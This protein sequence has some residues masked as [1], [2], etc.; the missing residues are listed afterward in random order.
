MIAVILSLMLAGQGIPLSGPQTGTVTGILK[1]SLGRP[2]PGVRVTALTKPDSV[3]DLASVSAMSGIAQTDA[4]GKF[5]LE[6][7]PPGGYFIAAGRLDVQTFYPGTPDVVDAKE[8][9][10]IAGATVSGVD[11][12][13]SDVSYGRAG[14]AGTLAVP[15][16]VSINGG[17]PIPV[18][19]NGALTFL[20]LEGIN[21]ATSTISAL[22]TRNVVNIPGPQV[23][24]YRVTIENL[25]ENYSVT[26]MTY[27]TTNLVTD[28]FRLRPSEFPAAPRGNQIEPLVIIKSPDGSIRYFTTANLPVAGFPILQLPQDVT[29]VRTLLAGTGP[30]LRQPVIVVDEDGAASLVTPASPAPPPSAASLPRSVISITLGKVAAKSRNGVRVS[31]KVNA[32]GAR[33]VHLSDIPGTVYA[34]GTFEV[35]GVPP[36]LHTVVTRNNPGGSSAMA[37]SIIVGERDLDGIVLTETPLIPRL[38]SG[39]SAE[40]HDPGPVPLARISGTIT[41]EQS[42]QPLPIKELQLKVEGSP[43][44]TIPVDN[45]GHFET[46]PLLPGFYR[47]EAPLFGHT[48]IREEVEIRDKNVTI[49]LHSSVM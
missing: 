10:V 1:D 19:G 46:P 11:F 43:G 4:E 8:V 2:V 22:L 38:T 30:G 37:A 44:L 27:G 3:S 45:K 15:I 25:P 17:G 36:G 47:F 7:I 23:S 24:A 49:E 13:M 34:D 35:F 41:E 32:S 33:S 5:R 31:G 14:V 42:H 9:N 6:G 39:L 40:A 18:S 28:P 29:A 12:A 48:T 16:Q 26:S 21:G 20:R